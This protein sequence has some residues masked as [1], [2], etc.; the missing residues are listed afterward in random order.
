VALDDALAALAIDDP[1]KAR[2]VE[3]RF[4]GGMT[5]EE[6]AASLGAPLHVVRR[7][8]RFAR[9]WLRQQMESLKGAKRRG[10]LPDISGQP[11]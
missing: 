11:L 7:D 6:I 8:L 9:A 3:M 5:A 4:F 2:L 10:N 1:W